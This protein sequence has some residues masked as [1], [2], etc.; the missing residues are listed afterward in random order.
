MTLQTT[1][2]RS[3]AARLAALVAAAC[4]SQLAPAEALAQQ[5]VSIKGRVVNMR[6]APSTSAEVMW[7]LSSGYPLV[8]VSRRGDWLQV[9]DFENDTGWV[10][11]SL[12]H[13]Q[14]HHIVKARTANIRSGPGTQHRVIGQARYGDVLRTREK[15]EGWVRVESDN[16]PAGWISRDLLWGW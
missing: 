14:P 13:A 3:I 16:Q 9:R 11:R 2:R 4:L 1:P 8:V 15:R 12:T 6:A 7:E 10:A 5:M